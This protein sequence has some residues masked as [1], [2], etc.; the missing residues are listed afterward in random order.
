VIQVESGK[1]PDGRRSDDPAYFVT[2]QH[3]EPGSV[4]H[5]AHT[6]RLHTTPGQIQHPTGWLGEA[7]ETVFCGLLGLSQ[8]ELTRLVETGIIA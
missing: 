2:L 1:F 6:I 3:P 7:N 5:L 4:E 8:D